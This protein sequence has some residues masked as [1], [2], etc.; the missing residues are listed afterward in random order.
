MVDP[1]KKARDAD[2][3]AAIEVVEG[4][5][6]DGQ[7]TSADR[8][9]RVERLLQ[10]GTVGEVQVMVRDLQPPVSRLAEMSVEE[11]AE[12]ASRNLAPQPPAPRPPAV[13]G[14][15]M[16]GV[17]AVVFGVFTVVGVAVPLVMLGSVDSIQSSGT[18][19][20]ISGS[21]RELELLTAEGYDELVA[22]V[23]DRTGSRTVFGATIYPGYAVVDVPVDGRSKRSAGYHYDGDWRDWAGSG[24]ADVERF[25]LDR[26]DGA[27]VERLV[28]KVE[29]LV[30]DPSASY[31]L[32]NARGREQGVCLSAYTTNEYDETAYLDARCNGRVVRTYVS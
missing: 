9:L 7:I 20:A 5:F 10:A 25:E 2:R 32:V 17:V 11:R 30:D 8:D 26:V 27:T 4:A 14:R 22:A 16:V 31:V 3:D 15:K 28:N 24:T 23:E 29:K 13:A 19:G 21:E 12:R 6:A 18:D 1:H